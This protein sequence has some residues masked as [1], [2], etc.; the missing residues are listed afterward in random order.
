MWFRYSYRNMD[1]LY[2]NSEDT[3]QP[4]HS[5]ASD[6]GLHYLPVTFEV[7]WGFQTKMG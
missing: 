4:L 7:G 5:A 1:K 6:L 2:A 3:H